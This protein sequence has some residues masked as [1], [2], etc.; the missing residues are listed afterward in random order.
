VKNKYLVI[1]FMHFRVFAY[2][3]LFS[4]KQKTPISEL[5]LNFK[6]FEIDVFR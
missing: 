1:C 5:F 6:N 4:V 3:Y 2:R